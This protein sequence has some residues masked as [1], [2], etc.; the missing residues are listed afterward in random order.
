MKGV[1]FSE[2][3]RWVEEAYSP[4][5]ADQMIT[6]A[7]LPSGGA[8]T[9][10]GNY[11]HTEAL[12]MLVQ[13]SEMTGTA[14]PQLAETYGV[15][16]APRFAEIYRDL[17]KGYTDTVTF[18]ND[19]DSKMHSEMT[20]LYPDARTP[21][22]VVEFEAK[23]ITLFYASHRPFADVAFGLVQGYIDYFK[24][25]LEVTRCEEPEGPH[26]GRFR[27]SRRSAA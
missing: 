26:E 11:P 21:K 7:A 6:A 25:D 17:F 19:V 15:W 9:A 23:E 8:Y 20:K 1:I 13:L 12:S 4:A 2:M 10:V 3:V 24:D 5:L 14:I 27:I 18:L 22:V 16:L